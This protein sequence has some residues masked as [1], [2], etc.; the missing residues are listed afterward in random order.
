M[1]TKE[2]AAELLNIHEQTLIRW[3]EH[4]LIARHAYNDHGEYL[5]EEPGPDMPAK[6]RSRWD[7]LVDRKPA[8]KE[9]TASKSSHSTGKDAV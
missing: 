5:Y 3:A 8:A 6:H 7:R 9:R 1:L 4:G 2:E